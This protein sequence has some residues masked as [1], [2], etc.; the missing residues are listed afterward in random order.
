MGN[1]VGKDKSKVEFDKSEVFQVSTQQRHSSKY[2]QAGFYLEWS[3]GSRTEVWVV[4]AVIA[5]QYYDVVS[6]DFAKA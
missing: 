6:I 3:S 2:D 4:V 1:T 5:K